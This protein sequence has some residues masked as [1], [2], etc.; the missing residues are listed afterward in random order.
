MN[1]LGLQKG[2][3][4]PAAATQGRFRTICGVA[5]L[6]ILCGRRAGIGA[7]RWPEPGPPA[8]LIIGREQDL[9]LW[10]GGLDLG[11]MAA[12]AGSGLGKGLL[13]RARGYCYALRSK[14]DSMSARTHG[15]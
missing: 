7:A 9:G 12:K 13:G 11:Q 5:Q 2:A 10:S 3:V 8:N 1:S 6:L 14:T 4:P 15:G